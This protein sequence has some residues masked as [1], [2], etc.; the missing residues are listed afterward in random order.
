MSHFN[1]ISVANTQ[2]HI[3][4]KIDAQERRA[5]DNRASRSKHHTRNL[6]A[7]LNQVA[8]D[9]S[10]PHSAFKVAYIIGEHINR[11][12]GEAWPSTARIA[13]GCALSQ[14]TVVGLVRQL[15]AA[16]HLAIDPGS[17]GRGHSHRYRMILKYRGADVLQLEKKTARPTAKTSG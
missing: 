1:T 7:W 2:D 10:L 11:D 9:G 8:R 14:S 17:A 3:A 4:I 5:A 15:E 16:G 6:H 12:S 13:E